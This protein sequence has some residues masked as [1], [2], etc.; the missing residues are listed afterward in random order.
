M[1]TLEAPPLAGSPWLRS[2][3]LVGVSYPDRLIELSCSP[4]SAR[5]TSRTPSSATA[6]AARRSSPAARLTASNAARTGSAPT[7]T[8]TRRA[9][10]A[11][12]RRLHPGAQVGLTAGVRVAH[13]P[14]GDETL[15]LADDGCLDASA[16]FL[17]MGEAGL[18]WNTRTSYRIDKGFLHHIALV[19]DGAYGEDAGV[20]AVRQHTPPPAVGERR[21]RRCSRASSCSCARRGSAIN[22]RWRG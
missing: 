15:A 8:T 16:A 19:P 20:L 9:P 11:A 10:S 17:P 7:A 2:A 1:T 4:T 18:R 6:P 3:E 21:R 22:A 13:T 12:P 14:L 5:S